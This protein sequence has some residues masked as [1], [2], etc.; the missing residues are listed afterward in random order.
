MAVDAESVSPPLTR[1]DL[2]QRLVGVGAGALATAL[3]AG[4]SV[5]SLTTAPP[6]RAAV[7]AGGLSTKRKFR[8]GMVIDTRR[9]VVTTATPVEN[10]M[11]DG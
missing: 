4:A 10:G 1:R 5:S 6:A 7:P 8:Y 3:A 2:V 11:L 9:C